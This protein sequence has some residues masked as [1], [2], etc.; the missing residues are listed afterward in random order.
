MHTRQWVGTDSGRGNGDSREELTSARHSI[1]TSLKHFA[2]PAGVALVRLDGHYGDA[3]VIAQLMLTGVYLVTRGRGE[4]LLEHQE[5]QG[6]LAHPPIASVSA[7]NTGEVVELF[8]GGWLPPYR[9]LPA[10]RVMVTRHPAPPPDKAVRVGKQRG[11][12]VYELFITTL[13]ADG[14]SSRGCARPLSR[15]RGLRGGA[16]F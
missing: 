2:L 8:G 13:E 14:L 9:G 1:T 7:T 15:T 12:W 4:S 5:I 11:E 3:A 10:A 6:V 16:G